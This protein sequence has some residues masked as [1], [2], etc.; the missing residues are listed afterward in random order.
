[1]SQK[2]S[3]VM[4]FV[5]LFGMLVAGMATNSDYFGA[6]LAQATYGQGKIMMVEAPMPQPFLPQEQ[7]PSSSSLVLVSTLH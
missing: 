2:T 6:V 4:L 3:V 7:R 1:M 5:F